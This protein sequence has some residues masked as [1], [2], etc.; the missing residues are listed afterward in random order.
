MPPSRPRDLTW[1]EYGEGCRLLP[2]FRG[3]LMLI[4]LPR[5]TR[6]YT[7]GSPK[8]LLRPWRRQHDEIGLRESL[9]ADDTDVFPKIMKTTISLATP[10]ELETESL[11]AVV[12]DHAESAANENE[13]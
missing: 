7:K 10:A 1:E 3:G 12:L 11:V 13:K 9:P 2:A 4:P 5:R 6:W 8:D